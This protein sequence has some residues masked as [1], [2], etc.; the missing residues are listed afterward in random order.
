MRA[1]EAKLTWLET[2]TKYREEV[3]YKT[4]Y[5]TRNVNEYLILYAG[6]L[7][8]AIGSITK[9]IEG[10]HRKQVSDAV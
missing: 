5:V 10:W 8:I 1:R 7:L 6:F 4:E 3:R 9:V 2:V